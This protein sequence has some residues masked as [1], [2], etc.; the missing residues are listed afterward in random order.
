MGRCQEQQKAP[1]N[2]NETSDPVDYDEIVLNAVQEVYH[3]L[4]AVEQILAM[5]PYAGYVEVFINFEEVDDL[6]QEGIIMVLPCED[7]T[8]NI[9]EDDLYTEDIETSR[10]LQLKSGLVN[11]NH[12]PSYD[13]SYEEYDSLQETDFTQEEEHGLLNDDEEMFPEM[14]QFSQALEQFRLSRDLY[15]EDPLAQEEIDYEIAELAQM[16]REELFGGSLENNQ[17]EMGDEDYTEHCSELEE[18]KI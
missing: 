6:D 11:E 2:E 3:G 9:A 15:F 18:S 8:N 14:S 10:Q 12:Q 1:L 5:L 16:M 17:M 7:N 4:D 13:W